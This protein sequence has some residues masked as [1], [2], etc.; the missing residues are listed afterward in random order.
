MVRDPPVE[1]KKILRSEVGFG[2]PVSGC[3]KPYLEWHH[4][5]PRWRV[6][7]HHDP[8]GMIALCREHHIKADHGAFALNQLREMKLRGKD[9]W[10]EVAGRFHWMR[11]RLLGVVGGNFFYE[12]EIFLQI[13]DTPVLWFERDENSY[14]LVNFSLDGFGERRAKIRNNDWYSTSFE[15]DI[16]CPPSGKSLSLQYQYGD[17]LKIE[18]LELH[19]IE[20]VKKRFTA[21]T[22]EK[23]PIE[24]PITAVEIAL[25]IASLK[26]DFDSKAANFEFGSMSNIFMSRLRACIS[27]HC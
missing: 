20:Q 5:D 16:E 1:I 12:T 8:A 25:R 11:N 18:F 26:I 24:L 19:S 6:R 13:N 9:N 4:F 17:S 7:N 10:L 14:I 2:C 22:P 15:E 27:L 21:S 3:G 23:W